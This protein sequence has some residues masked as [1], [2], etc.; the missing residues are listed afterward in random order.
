MKRVLGI[1]PIAIIIIYL[2]ISNNNSDYTN[3][4]RNGLETFMNENPDYVYIDVRTNEEYNNG[5][6]NGFINISSEVAVDV[7][8][9]TYDKDEPIVLICR[10]GNRSSNVAKELVKLG[11]TNIY[12]VEF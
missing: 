2:I 5:H 4:N 7:I 11:Y 8:A 3:I 9:D 12:N 6:I 1:I 10:S